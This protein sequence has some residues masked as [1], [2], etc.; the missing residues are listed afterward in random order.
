M[1]PI[2]GM[3]GNWYV[4]IIPPNNR[5]IMAKLFIKYIYSISN[6]SVIL[7]QSGN[8]GAAKAW[9]SKGGSALPPVELNLTH[10]Y[11]KQLTQLKMEKKQ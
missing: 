2:L 6:S 8:C 7:P 3:I 10:I 9:G 1:L 5:H 11:I 4:I